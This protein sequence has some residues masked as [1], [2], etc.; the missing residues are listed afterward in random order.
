MLNEIES[1][2]LTPPIRRIASDALSSIPLD[3]INSNEQINISYPS[4]SIKKLKKTSYNLV[5]QSI[6]KNNCEQPT[7]LRERSTSS[8]SSSSKSS[9]NH[10]FKSLSANPS[11]NDDDD[12]DDASSNDDTNRQWDLDQLVSNIPLRQLSK[13]THFIFNEY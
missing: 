6:K 1:S 7:V 8:S 4:I 11:L 12:D 3:N 10:S 13:L 2:N 9:N 5:K